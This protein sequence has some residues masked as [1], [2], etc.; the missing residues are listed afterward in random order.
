[1]LTSAMSQVNDDELAAAAQEV[2]DEAFEA[3]PR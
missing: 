1:M 3:L 2:P